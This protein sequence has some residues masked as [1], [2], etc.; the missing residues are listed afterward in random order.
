[1]VVHVIEDVLAGEL[2]GKTIFES[3]RRPTAEI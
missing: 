2:A 1:M 3:I